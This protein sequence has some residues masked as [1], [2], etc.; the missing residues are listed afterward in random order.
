MIAII[1][2]I[3][4]RSIYYIL[5]NTYILWGGIKFL[6]IATHRNLNHIYI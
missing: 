2:A 4:K 6:N 3:I 5:Y 1:I